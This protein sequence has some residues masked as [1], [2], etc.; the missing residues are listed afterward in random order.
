MSKGQ[1]DIVEVP[2]HVGKDDG[3]ELLSD[4]QRLRVA[5]DELQIR[6]FP[7]GDVDHAGTQIDPETPARLDRMQ[8]V[9][10]PAADLEDR[11]SSRDQGLAQPLDFAVICPVPGLPRIPDRSQLVEVSPPHR[12]VRARRCR[13]VRVPPRWHP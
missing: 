6:V 1:P 9:A 4:V 12:F 2:D 13:S 5:H 3:V 7:P 10:G 8:E 11:R